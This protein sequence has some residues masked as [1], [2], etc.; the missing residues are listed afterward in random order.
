[1]FPS[2]SASS[3]LALHAKKDVYVCRFCIRSTSASSSVMVLSGGKSSSH[4]WPIS[5]MSSIRAPPFGM[6][7]YFSGLNARTLN[8]S[9]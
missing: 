2:N 3:S 1:M 6:V 5:S 9:K 8:P 4:T 7:K